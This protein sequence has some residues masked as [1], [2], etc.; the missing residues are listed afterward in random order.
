[1]NELLEDIVVR[2]IIDEFT[3]GKFDLLS[4]LFLASLLLFALLLF[5]GFLAGQSLHVE[6]F[7][8]DELVD[9]LG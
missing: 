2:N 7:L 6:K 1:M 4:L 9:F 5:L 3:A 8:L